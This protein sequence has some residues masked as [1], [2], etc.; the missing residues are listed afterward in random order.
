VIR[1]SRSIVPNSF[2]VGN[3]L[4]G[5]M[6][7]VFAVNQKYFVMSAWLIGLAA[8]LDAIDGKVAR[9]TNSSS[10]FGIEYDSLADVVS[11]G[12]APSILIYQF[13]FNQLNQVGL[14]FSFLPLVFGSIR[15]ARFNVQLTGY[16]KTHFSG[17]PI[18]IAAITIGSYILLVEK[19]FDGQAF[20]RF[21][22]TITIVVAL[23]MV[24]NVR[25]EVFPNLTFRGNKK[26]KIIFMSLLVFGLLI[27]YF[28][29][30]LFFPMMILYI[31]SG[32]VK[33]ALSKTSEQRQRYKDNKTKKNNE[34]GQALQSKTDSLE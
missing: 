1:L 26:Q 16:T 32:L 3:M 4:C 6:S 17:L 29:Y 18:P 10:K 19:Y 33:E 15:L 24:T 30:L 21:L 5:Y 8:F 23:L 7:I 20:P 34:R 11:F 31:S 25:Y 27:L 12:V 13:Y 9:I 28:P 22:M 14:L 2:T